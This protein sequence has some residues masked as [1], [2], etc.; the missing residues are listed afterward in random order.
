MAPPVPP[1]HYYEA[2]SCS[3]ASCKSVKVKKYIITLIK[4]AVWTDQLLLPF[5][6][7]FNTHRAKIESHVC[8]YE[9]CTLI[10]FHINRVLIYLI[11]FQVVYRNYPKLLH[12]EST[13]Y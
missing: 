7:H 2:T 4:Q 10:H 5:I 3:A 12:L 1:P 13:K 9:L 8:V 11:T 6:W